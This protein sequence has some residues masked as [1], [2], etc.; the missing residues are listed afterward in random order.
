MFLFSRPGARVG[1]FGIISALSSA[2]GGNVFGLGISMAGRATTGGRM[3]MTCRLLSTTG[4]IITRNGA[5]YPIAT[6]KRGDVSFRTT[7][8]G[9]GA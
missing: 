5:P 6:S 3:A 7:L 4:G 8:D 9:I 1:S 2:C